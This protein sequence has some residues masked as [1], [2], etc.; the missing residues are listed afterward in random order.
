[1]GSG[2]IWHKRHPYDMITSENN[3][4]E[5]FRFPH[6]MN[7]PLPK[8]AFPGSSGKQVTLTINEKPGTGEAVFKVRNSPHATGLSYETEGNSGNLLP[9][10]YLLQ[11]ESEE[12]RAKSDEEETKIREATNAIKNVIKL[13]GQDNRRGRT[14]LIQQATQDFRGD[15]KSLEAGREL[16]EYEAQVAQAQN[17]D[18]AKARAQALSQQSGQEFSPN[19][20]E[21]GFRP[22]NY[23]VVSTSDSK[24]WK[25]LAHVLAIQ[26]KRVLNHMEDREMEN[27]YEKEK[28][29]E[30]MMVMAQQ[31]MMGRDEDEG[32]DN[33]NDEDNDDDDDEMPNN[34]EKRRHSV[35]SPYAKK[36]PENS[37][38]NTKTEKKLYKT[39]SSKKFIEHNL[40][41]RAV[42]K[43]SRLEKVHKSKKQKRRLVK[44]QKSLK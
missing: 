19:E 9:S 32:P 13:F 12:A 28:I 5:T 20:V 35:F 6:Q 22:P 40:V 29:Q 31:Q 36:R 34:R 27:R 4:S 25:N 11:S 30:E 17:Q 7:R 18:R 43:L 1:M 24:E 14:K 37:T 41:H 15:S 38:K 42:K 3:H 16:S 26:L 23:A 21:P 10:S 2:Y 33:E 8:H 39:N 44:R